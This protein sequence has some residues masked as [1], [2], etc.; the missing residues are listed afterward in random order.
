[1]KTILLLALFILLAGCQSSKPRYSDETS[2]NAEGNYH[3]ATNLNDRFYVRRP[4]PEHDG[5]ANVPFYFKQC[6]RSTGDFYD[7]RTR[8]NCN[9]P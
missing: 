5:N 8:Y 1:V 4:M 3:P 2:M 7:T 9:Y 6:S